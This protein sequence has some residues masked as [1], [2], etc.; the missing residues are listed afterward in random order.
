MV[1]KVTWYSPDGQ[2]SALKSGNL[3]HMNFIKIPR[4][5]INSLAVC[6]K[7]TGNDKH[8]LVSLDCDH[9]QGKK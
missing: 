6:P 9:C 1:A 7:I 8:S 5:N 4:F 2:F 3:P